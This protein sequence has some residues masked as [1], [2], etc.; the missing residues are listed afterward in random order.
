M[1]AHDG[2]LTACPRPERVGGRRSSRRLFGWSG[3]VD[4]GLDEPR[5][6]KASRAARRMRGPPKPA[7]CA[8]GGGEGTR[9]AGGAGRGPGAA[10]GEEGYT[11][12]TSTGPE[13]A[14][15][16]WPGPARLGAGGGSSWAS[17]LGH[18]TGR[19]TASAVAS[20][21][22][23]VQWPRRMAARARRR[24]S[25]CLVRLDGPEQQQGRVVDMTATAAKEPCRRR[26]Y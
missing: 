15:R 16:T 24:D 5:L 19:Q 9:G 21:S 11:D 12:A 10:V 26:L 8:A 25:P 1:G 3:P 6:G 2:C 23:L 14:R 7:F 4:E 17:G 13:T 22:G 20:C 18:N